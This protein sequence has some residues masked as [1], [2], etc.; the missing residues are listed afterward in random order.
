[1]V[2][3]E[4]RRCRDVLSDRV[5]ASVTASRGVEG[6]VGGAEK[7]PPIRARVRD[8]RPSRLLEGMDPR[9][10]RRVAATAAGTGLSLALGVQPADAGVG[11]ASNTWQRAQTLSAPGEYATYPVAGF[12]GQGD[13]VAVWAQLKGT[14]VDYQIV[15]ASRPAGSKTWERPVA[16][17]P[18]AQFADFPE[19]AV[20]ASGAAVAVW[21]AGGVAVKP[22]VGNPFIQAAFRPSATAPWGPAVRLT[23]PSVSASEPSVAID[24]EG[25]ATVIWTT[26]TLVQSSTRDATTGKWSTG[27]TIGAVPK[28]SLASGLRV[29]ASPR[30]AVIAVWKQYVSG[31]VLTGETNHIEAAIRLAGH[32][33]WRSPVLLGTEVEVPGQGSATFEPPEPDVALD[34]QGDAVCVFQG[35][36]HG[37]IVID[38]TLRSARTGGWQQASPISGNPGLD[39]IVAM[40]ADGGTTAVWQGSGTTVV[41]ASRI[42]TGPWSTR[43]FSNANPYAEPFPQVSLDSR[44]GAV[45]TWIGPEI[46]V[47]TRSGFRGAWTKPTS[48]G[49]GGVVQSAISPAGDGLAI[50]Q[51]PTSKPRGIAV[52]AAM[53]GS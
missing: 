9:M 12:D 26:G 25:S 51:V 13:A 29:A 5:D 34:A 50:W 20:D 18:R 40:D 45:A 42:L 23:A 53:E 11:G 41:A 6:V 28:S 39:P 3:G 44:G 46:E 17:S 10:L 14:G 8:S 52:Q 30:G 15:A 27:S 21:A 7:R 22:P 2:V 43:I 38:A 36:Y 16:L 48:V 37:S 24:G 35:R 1:V 31:G 32:G 33:T 4:E 47:A 19:V 49:E